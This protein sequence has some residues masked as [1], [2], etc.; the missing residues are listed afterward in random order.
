MG[1][2]SVFPRQCEGHPV[3]R[4][5]DNPSR[6]VC[7]CSRP[8]CTF[9]TKVDTDLVITCPISS[10]EAHPRPA[11]RTKIRTK[12]QCRDRT[13]TP[14]VSSGHRPGGHQPPRH[15]PGGHQQ[16][17][18]R[19]AERGSSKSEPHPE[20]RKSGCDRFLPRRA[21]RKSDRGIEDI[22]NRA[23]IPRT[24]ENKTDVISTDVK[25]IVPSS[26]VRH[27]SSFSNYVV[28]DTNVL[29]DRRFKIEKFIAD[30]DACVVI[31]SIVMKELRGLQSCAPHPS[32][33]RRRKSWKERRARRAR[34]AYNSIRRHLSKGHPRVLGLEGDYGDWIDYFQPES[35]DDVILQNCLALME[36]YPSSKVQLF[37]QDKRLQDDASSY[38][39]QVISLPPLEIEDIRNRAEIPRTDENNTDVIN[40]D[41]SSI[42]PSWSARS[43]PTPHPRNDIGYEGE[44]GDGEDDGYEYDE[45]EDDEDEGPFKDKFDSSCRNY[46]VIDTNVL[47]DRRFRIEKFIADSDACVVIPSIVLRELRGL[48]SCSPRPSSRR[49]RMSNKERRA[50]KARWAYNNIR[51][52]LSSRHPRILD[53]ERN[54]GDWIDYFQPASNDDIILKNCLALMEDHPSAKIQLFTQDRRL[55]SDAMRYGVDVISLPPLVH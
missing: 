20:W 23:E 39:V 45:A 53:L 51:R 14:A 2:T 36:D 44:D 41:V 17:K 40:T 3:K 4:S 43:V 37:T 55:Q 25:S 1:N 19:V 30:S 18:L 22:Q 27:D 9:T 8:H 13:G 29:F 33:H 38:A 12:I 49:R 52:H 16:S 6:H 54:Y 15:R 50:R 34:W 46:V 5:A 28:I 47:L 42:V 11:G 7:H 35:N 32:S 21:P 48:Q 31:P 10:S 24:D 26:P